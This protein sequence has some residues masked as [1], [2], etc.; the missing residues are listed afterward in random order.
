M[1]FHAQLLAVHARFQDVS[2]GLVV[3]TSDLHDF[4]R[5]SLAGPSFSLV[6]PS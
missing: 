2:S 1:N 3:A 4:L 6:I 5:R